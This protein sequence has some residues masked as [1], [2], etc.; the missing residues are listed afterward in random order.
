MK[1]KYRFARLGPDFLMDEL[2]ESLKSDS[3]FQF[4][5]LFLQIFAKLKARKAAGAGEEMLRL[6][7]YEKLHNLVQRGIVEKNGNNYRG[8]ASALAKYY[9]DVAAQQWPRM[10][11]I[12]KK[13]NE[14]AQQPKEAGECPP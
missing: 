14:G 3:W 12:L 11:A 13:R 7:T 2:T 5:P 4:S 9:G 1:P 8:I 6:R 10:L